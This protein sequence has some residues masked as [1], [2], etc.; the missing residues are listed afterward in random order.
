[1]LDAKDFKKVASAGFGDPHNSHAWSMEWFKGRLY[2]G[3]SRDILWVF[4]RVGTYLLRLH[5]MRSPQ[6]PP[7]WPT[8]LQ[9]GVR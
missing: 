9:V 3:T 2:V 5:A 7:L 6:T 1:M 4:A 8:H